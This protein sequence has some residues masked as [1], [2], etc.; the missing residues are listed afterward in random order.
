VRHRYWPKYSQVLRSCGYSPCLGSGLLQGRKLFP[1]KHSGS[2]PAPVP[3]LQDRHSAPIRTGVRWFRLYPSRYPDPLRF[4]YSASRFS[5]PRTDLPEPDRFG[6]VYFFSS[7][8]VCF[9]ERVLS[10]RRN[11]RGR[12]S[13]N[14]IRGAR[15][16]DF[17]GTNGRLAVEP[18]FSRVV[19][20]QRS[21]KTATKCRN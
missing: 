12:G 20:W 3:R 16:I 5:D 1:R 9:L 17:C 13:P 4:G 6:V 19:T 8:I 15:I 2:R 14:P 21:L 10:D 11:G 7:L 18:G